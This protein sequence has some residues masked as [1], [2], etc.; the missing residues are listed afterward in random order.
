MTVWCD[1]CSNVHAD[2]RSP[3]KPWTWRC[4]KAPSRS[5]YGFVSRF[6]APA[7]PFFRCVDVNKNG[8]CEMFEP[9]RVLPDDE[10]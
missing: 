6:Y 10:E 3:D 4:A 5:G 9:I 1:A 2:T 7:P 8:D